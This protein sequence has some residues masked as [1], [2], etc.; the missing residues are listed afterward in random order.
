MKTLLHLG[1]E[2]PKIIHTLGLWR[3][4]YFREFPYL[5]EGNIDYE[6]A[7]LNNYIKGKDSVI[8]C[9]EVEKEPIAIASGTSLM[10]EMD[11]TT[12]SM[13]ELSN[14]IPVESTAYLGE[15]IISEAY[16]GKGLSKTII[17]QL[18]NHFKNLNYTHTCFLTVVR[19]NH[20]LE[21]KNYIKPSVF[22]IANGYTKTFVSSSFHWPCIQENGK[23]IEC[24]NEMIYWV[25]SL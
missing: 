23:I 18:E 1:D 13:Q 16:R 22:W 24:E 14:L 8:L 5:Y 21:P 9:I 6:Q 15:I 17:S 19:N 11:I 2:L 20:P 25:K 12:R 7:Y 10:S 4:K 3:I